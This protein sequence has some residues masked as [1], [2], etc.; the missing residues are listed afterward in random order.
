MM[1]GCPAPP[2]ADS[3]SGG[4][5]LVE[6]A[7]RLDTT[8]EPD[9]QKAAPESGR[10][11]GAADSAAALDETPLHHATTD[12]LLTLITLPTSD[13]QTN[14]GE[15]VLRS[16]VGPVPGRFNQGNPTNGRHDITR[17][18]CLDGLRGIT[19]QTDEQ[20]RTCHGMA[21]MVPIY[22][23]GDPD[24]AKTCIDVF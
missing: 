11:A 2:R 6:A 8:L 19:L 7:S 14:R 12:E 4:A 23:G 1:L 24:T 22:T 5:A 20:R 9:A 3:R 21:N 13:A 18:A 16:L 10:G 15:L 17:G